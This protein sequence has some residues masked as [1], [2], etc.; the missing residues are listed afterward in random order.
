M[1]AFMVWAKTERK[2]LA[3]ENPE[4]HNA[5]LSKMLGQKWRSLSPSQKKYYNEQ[6]DKLRELHMKKYPNYKYRPRR[7]KTKFRGSL[8]DL[9]LSNI[10]VSKQVE[11]ECVSKSTNL[12]PPASPEVSQRDAPPFLISQ[13]NYAA[14]Q[15]GSGFDHTSIQ[16][17][18][19]CL[20]FPD[21]PPYQNNFQGFV[22]PMGSQ[23]AQAEVRMYSD[24]Q[25]LTY[26][27]EAG[28]VLS[29]VQET[30]PKTQPPQLNDY[31]LSSQELRD[32]SE[33]DSTEF[34][35]YLKTDQNKCK[36]G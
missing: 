16:P 10:H 25:C 27:S 21:T 28:T 29:G 2:K 15:V 31:V 6:A 36:N 1:N 23:D 26:W 20:G 34:D 30:E 9:S 3:A 33:I 32:V 11:I 13:I 14:E 12:T 4:V 17:S 5:D 19:I 8:D 24:E 35:Q 7:K 18:T 22:F